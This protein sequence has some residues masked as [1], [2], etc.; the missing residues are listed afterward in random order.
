MTF[1]SDDFVEIMQQRRTSIAN[2]NGVTYPITG[3]GRVAL[4]PSF[5]LSNTLLV[6]SLSNKLMFIGQATE[7]LNCVVLIYPTF[8]L[9]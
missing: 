8:S 6:Q 7:E 3:A 2:A 4:S 9:F 1:C 5:S